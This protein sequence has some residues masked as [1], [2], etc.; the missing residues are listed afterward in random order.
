MKKIESKWLNLNNFL[1]ATFGAF[2]SFPVIFIKGSFFI[3]ILL[4]SK[5]D[6]DYFN[7][8]NYVCKTASNGAYSHKKKMHVG[9]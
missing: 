1:H 7:H 5:K 2:L 3:I 4:G 6:Y 8:L 9:E